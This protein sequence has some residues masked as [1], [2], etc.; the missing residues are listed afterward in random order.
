VEAFCGVSACV[1]R[2]Y[3]YR[4]LLFSAQSHARHQLF[5]TTRDDIKRPTRPRRI[6]THRVYVLLL[7]PARR[8]RSSSVFSKTIRQL[9][10]GTATS[11]R[12][13]RR[14]GDRRG[15]GAARGQRTDDDG[16]GGCSD[17]LAWS[18]WDVRGRCGWDGRRTWW[19]CFRRTR[20]RER[21]RTWRQA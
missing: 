14:G 16:D 10:T 1:E 8:R 12:K 17:G 7:F 15:T 13:Q 2:P 4:S 6:S 19:C 9:G 11:G 3:S 20:T 5:P 21:E 18:G